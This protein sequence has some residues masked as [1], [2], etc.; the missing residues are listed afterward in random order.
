MSIK[1]FEVAIKNLPTKKIAGLSGFTVA[2]YQTQ[3]KTSNL[4]K[5]RKKMSWAYFPT[6]FM[7][8][9]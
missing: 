3:M 7:R 6:H 8:P 4:Y 1:N 9:S 2:F 5:P